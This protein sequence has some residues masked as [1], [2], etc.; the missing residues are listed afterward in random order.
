[1]LALTGEFLCVDEN[2]QLTPWL[3][4]SWTSN[5]DA[6]SGR[7]RSARASTFN[8]GTPDDGEGRR[9]VDQP[10]G[11]PRQ[12]VERAVGVHRRALEGLAPRPPDDATVVFKLDAPERL[13]PVLPVERQLQRDHPARRRTPAT[14]RRRSRA[15]ARGS[16]TPTRRASARRSSATTATGARRPSRTSSRS[17]SRPTRPRRSWRCRATS[18]TS[19]SRCR[20]RARRRSWTT[21]RT[22]I[23][24]LQSAAH[25]QL[26]MRTDKKPFDDAR[27]RQAI[28]LAVDR[29]AIVDGLFQGKSDLGNDSPFAPDLPADRHDRRRSGR[30]D[31]DKAKSL[32]VRRRRPERVRDRAGRDSRPRRSRSTRR[33]W[34]TPRR[35]SASPSSSRSRTAA[36]TT[37]RPC[38]ASRTGSTRS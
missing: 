38:T 2:K 29:Q 3:A 11:R 13:V 9:R 15:P 21:R 37:A 20:C 12:Q 33:S 31:I 28:A 17:P 30:K 19:C 6:T 8:D 24:A 14:S 10:D 18:S 32:L 27:V 23:I 26:S 5:T 1:M 36:R 34:S 35:R 4:E 22:T 7:S 25:R 16:S